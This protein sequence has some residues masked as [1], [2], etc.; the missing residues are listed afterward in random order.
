MDI[1]P[2]GYQAFSSQSQRH[3]CS[4]VAEQC[5]LP[6]AAMAQ[7]LAMRMVPWM[8]SRWQQPMGHCPAQ[9]LPVGAASV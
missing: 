3:L 7:L 6:L 9:H 4:C 5:L 2:M 1:N 8:A